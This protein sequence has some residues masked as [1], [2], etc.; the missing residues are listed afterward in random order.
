MKYYY[1]ITTKIFTS[2]KNQGWT[3]VYYQC[4]KNEPCILTYILKGHCIILLWRICIFLLGRT[5]RGVY[6]QSCGLCV[7]K[8]KFLFSKTALTFEIGYRLHCLH[9]TL[10]L[11]ICHYNDS[12]MTYTWKNT[13]PTLVLYCLFFLLF[14]SHSTGIVQCCVYV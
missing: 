8:M 10:T 3:I 6:T 9:V 7:S 2:P 5:Q 14:F 13:D 1:K 4:N 12:C 11:W